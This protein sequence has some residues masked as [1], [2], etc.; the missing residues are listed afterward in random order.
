[1]TFASHDGK[2]LCSKT[3]ALFLLSGST[4][5]LIRADMKKNFCLLDPG[6]ASLRTLFVLFMAVSAILFSGD[7]DSALS[8]GPGTSGSDIKI[9]RHH[10][11]EPP[12][13]SAVRKP[14]H[15][16]HVLKDG[17]APS[18]ADT[19][20]PKRPPAAVKPKKRLIIPP[21]ITR[22]DRKST[23]LSVTFD[24]GLGARE[25]GE[26]LDTLKKRNIRTTIFLSGNFIRFNPEITRRIVAEGHEVGNHTTT[27]PHLTQLEING[28]QRTLPSVTKD[29]LLSQ[30]NETERRFFE[31]TGK[32]L[33]P[34]WRAPYGEVNSEL[35]A[36][37]YSAGYLHVG[38]TYDA[39]S[40][41]SLD[42]LDWVTD[43]GSRLYHGPDDIK[44]KILDFDKKG[45]G[46]GGGIILMHLDTERGPDRASSV[47]G[48]I[49]DS[50]IERGFSLVKVSDLVPNKRLLREA[51]L[52]KE[53][54]YSALKLRP[55][56][57][58]K[59]RLARHVQAMASPVHGS[60]K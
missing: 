14:G 56:A 27:H 4:L 38:W 3:K 52:R 26:I 5:L 39:R 9:V 41:R 12:D 24:G 44:K 17:L 7:I 32:H 48:D 45:G 8:M 33:S 22:G 25:A 40:G 6:T 37:A 60:A 13:N 47:L 30:L 51:R 19:Q 46:L 50:L 18:Y 54:F 49:L 20:G 11:T 55:K 10:E 43:K 57:A 42:S 36:W 23:R 29:F 59:P 2:S 28:T 31:V 15:R 16:L 35:R 21:N 1:M 58:P 53:R 34:L